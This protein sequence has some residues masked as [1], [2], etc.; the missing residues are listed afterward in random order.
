MTKGDFW[1]CGK[2][3]ALDWLFFLGY[4]LFLELRLVLCLISEF[5]NCG[6]GTFHT[7]ALVLK[8]VY[9]S[10][11]VG[12]SCTSFVSL[13]WVYY[14]C[15]KRALISAE[16]VRPSTLHVCCVGRGPI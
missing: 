3:R 15:T 10:Y 12:M 6:I 9:I 8:P 7:K 11:N 2:L 14:S 16:A 4:V 1:G 13:R 5:L